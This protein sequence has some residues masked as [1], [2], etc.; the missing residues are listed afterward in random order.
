MLAQM[1]QESYS[2]I[3]WRL[4]ERP[5]TCTCTNASP[6]DKDRVAE[7]EEQ[8]AE[9]D[10]PQRVERRQL[11]KAGQHHRDDYDEMVQLQGTIRCQARVHYL[12]VHVR[13]SNTKS[14]RCI[15]WMVSS[16]KLSLVK[17]QTF[18]CSRYIK[19]SANV[20]YWQCHA[21]SECPKLSSR[22]QI[23]NLTMECRSAG[24]WNYQ[25]FLCQN[26]AA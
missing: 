12:Q 26:R 16:W 3:M 5:M 23:T 10:V 8:R 11:R 7:A 4:F 15:G 6:G 2:S 22:F 14:A 25:A 20:C 9:V 24:L 21:V 19:D 18:S 1:F 17:L 13:S